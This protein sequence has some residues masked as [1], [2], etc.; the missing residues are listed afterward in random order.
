MSWGEVS[1]HPDYRK[2][3]L[4][5]TAAETVYTTLFNAQSDFAIKK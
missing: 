2:H 1:L 5:G 3:V 4:R